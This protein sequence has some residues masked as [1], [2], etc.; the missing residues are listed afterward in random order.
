MFV[1]PFA[2]VWSIGGLTSGLDE[3]CEDVE[4]G[5]QGIGAALLVY[6]LCT[7]V[8]AMISCC[9]EVSRLGKA[10]YEGRTNQNSIPPAQLATHMFVPSFSGK[11][12]ATTLLVGFLGRC[13]SS[14]LNMAVTVGTQCAGYPAVPSPHQAPQGQYMQAPDAVPVGTAAQAYASAPPAEPVEQPGMFQK[15]QQAFHR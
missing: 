15:M 9:W 1:Y 4:S 10:R 2:L 11:P 3:D 12:G 5:T 6:L 14:A 13:H 7:V 8:V